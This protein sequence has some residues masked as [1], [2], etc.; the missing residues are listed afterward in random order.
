M[1]LPRFGRHLMACGIATIIT[2]YTRS[3]RLLPYFAETIPRLLSLLNSVA[4]LANKTLVS[5]YL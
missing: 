1:G 4:V 3:R 5:V 2:H